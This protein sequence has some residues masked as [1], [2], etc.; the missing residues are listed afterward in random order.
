[1]TEEK[2]IGMEKKERV[3]EE[4]KQRDQGGRKRRSTIGREGKIW[5]EEYQMR[6]SEKGTNKEQRYQH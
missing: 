6:T 4:K 1:M 2:K 3:V 5:W